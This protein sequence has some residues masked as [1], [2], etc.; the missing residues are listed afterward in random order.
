M[1]SGPVL[2]SQPAYDSGDESDGREEYLWAPVIAGFH[3]SPILEPAE[4]NLDPITPFVAAFVIFDGGLAFLP[5]RDSGSYPFVV[6]GFFEPIGVATSISEQPIDIGQAAQKSLCP[7]VIT[8]LPSG[9]KQVQ[10]GA[11]LS[12][13]ACNLVFIPPLV[14]PL[15]AASFGC[16]CRAVNQVTASPFF[17]K[18][19]G[20]PRVDDRKVL[21]GIIFINRN[22]LRWRDAPAAYGPHKT[23]YSRWKRRS[24]K[25]I[26]ARMM[27]GLAA[28]HG[29][30][31]TVMIPSHRNCVSTAGQWMRH[32]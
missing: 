23:L 20:K 4:H 32:I 1:G 15:S 22:G 8:H 18:S 31:Q 5:T 19:H 16:A 21:S 3:T 26:F 7:D 14:L 28:E 29:E 11:L 10:W 30:K 25:G 13:M 27:A 24:E 2:V 17:P 12:Q 6:Q 9:Y